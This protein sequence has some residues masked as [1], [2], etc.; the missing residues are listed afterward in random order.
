MLLITEDDYKGILLNNINVTTKKLKKKLK[1]DELLLDEDYDGVDR[2]LNEI[3]KYALIDT[4]L[5]PLK[6]THNDY[7]RDLHFLNYM[8]EYHPKQELKEYLTNYL[9]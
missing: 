1:N 8:S 2:A 3:F 4:G 7:L 5:M 6:L 9:L